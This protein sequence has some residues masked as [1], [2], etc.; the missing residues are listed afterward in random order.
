MRVLL[1]GELAAR[2]IIERR[3]LHCSAFAVERHESEGHD[4]KACEVG[5]TGSQQGRTRGCRIQG[6]RLWQVIA[7]P[8]SGIHAVSSHCGHELEG[9]TKSKYRCFPLHCRYIISTTMFG[10]TAIGITPQI[11]W[12]KGNYA[13]SQLH[14]WESPFLGR[15]KVVMIHC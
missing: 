3:Q 8:N 6:R 1:T 9:D 15:F 13:L 12:S 14:A 4:L 2:E 11:D 7:G 5:S 10:V